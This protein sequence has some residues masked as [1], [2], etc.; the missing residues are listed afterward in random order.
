LVGRL[1]RIGVAVA[2]TALVLY[3]SHP[4]QILAVTAAADWRWLAAALALVLVDRSLMAMRW[5]DLLVALAPGTRPPLGAVLRVFFTSSFVSN[6]VPSV[7]SDLYRAYALSR[8]DVHLSEST[9]SVLMDRALGVLSVVLVVT[10]VLPFA[11]GLTARRELIGVVAAVFTL[12]AVAAAVIYSERAADMVRRAAAAIPIKVLHRVTDALTD[13]VRRYATHHGEVTRVLAMSVLVQ[14]IRVLQGW[15][16]GCSLGLEV[17][18]FTYFV[19]IPIIV[20]IMQ[21]PIT[22][23]GLGTTQAAFAWLFVPQGAPASG[24]FALSVLFLVLGAVGTLPGGVLYA[25]NRGPRGSGRHG[26][27]G[28]HAP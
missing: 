5:I 8:Y 7:A 26:A 6:F 16:L 27:H 1:L 28:Q 23:N 21:V 10:A 2:L 20:L 13:A 11:D 14:I 24:A 12:C 25:I 19:F 18:L 3:W 17:P 22:L 4:S 9:A 15:C